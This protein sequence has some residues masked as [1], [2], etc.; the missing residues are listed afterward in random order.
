MGRKSPHFQFYN[1]KSYCKQ[2]V[3]SAK[4]L[5]IE[6]N[7]FYINLGEAR[8]TLTED[9]FHLRNADDLTLY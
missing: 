5:S 4:E 8:N 9:K 7:N 3:L 6:E 1:F 2:Y